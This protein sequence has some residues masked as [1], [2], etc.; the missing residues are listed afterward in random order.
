M[1]S[2]SVSEPAASNEIDWTIVGAWS[3]YDFA[4]QAF[5]TLVV[6]FVYSAYFT[7]GIATNEVIGTTQWSWAV[8]VSSVL[9]ATTAPYLGAMADRTGH[10]KRFLLGATVVCIAAT[11][12]LVLPTS[13][14]IWFALS[15]FVVANVAFELSYVF[16]N[17]FL[18][19]LAPGDMM[20]RVSGV[21]WFV[22]YIGG[23][24]SLIIALGVFIWP[25]TPPF[26]LSAETGAHVRATNILVAA[27]YSVFAV[28]LFWCVPEPSR[29]LFFATKGTGIVQATNQQLASTF[30]TIRQFKDAFWLLAARFFYNDGV[31]TIF[32]F[33]GIYAAGTFGFDTQGIIVFGIVLNVAAAVGAALFGYVDDWIGAKPTI[34]FTLVGISAAIVLAAVAPNETWFWTAGIV[35]GLLVGPNQSS[36]RSLMGRFTPASREN[37]FF[38][39]YAFSGKLT[40]FFGPLL[41]G[42]FTSLFDSQRVGISTVLV[43]FVVGGLLLLKV[44]EEE[45]LR[46][47]EPGR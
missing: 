34:L 45:G 37:E 23:L 44:D 38:G 7:Q 39:F 24:L 9:V 28:P 41:L 47:A 29:G 30:R 15:V 20:G 32:A 40:S 26:G 22:G 31:V 6:T 19:E 11:T 27:W 46:Q 14:Q 21:G 10:R 17:A 33:G 5:T 12:V 2:S 3:L 18:P 42:W 1:S 36:S 8:A 25:E 16:Y 13:G 4:N 35:I 43:F